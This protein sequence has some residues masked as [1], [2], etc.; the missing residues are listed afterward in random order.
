MKFGTD[1]LP[2]MQFLKLKKIIDP[3]FFKNDDVNTFS[4][5][6]SKKLW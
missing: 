5:A 1:I 2:A 3:T 6:V 4:D